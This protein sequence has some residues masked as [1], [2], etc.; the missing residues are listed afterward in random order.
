MLCLLEEWTRTWP[1]G[2]TDTMFQEWNPD[3][4]KRLRSERGSRKQTNIWRAAHLGQMT[5]GIKSK[6]IQSASTLNSYLSS[7]R[8]LSSFSNFTWC[9]EWLQ[10]G[11]SKPKPSQTE[12][13]AGKWGASF[14]R[15]S[16][17]LCT[18][19]GNA[20]FPVL[21]IYSKVWVPQISFLLTCWPKHFSD[22]ALTPAI[23]HEVEGTLKPW[24]PRSLRDKNKAE[25]G[26]EAA[27]V[28]Q[29]PCQ[30]RRV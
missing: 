19:K 20:F 15:L 6:G 24:P 14:P 2:W 21:M 27:G 9:Q 16:A 25:C 29:P 7:Q 13:G 26:G 11:I 10:F 30:R 5:A 1:A 12:S 3:I 4:W 22:Q 23:S 8:S 28:N 18:G 17:E